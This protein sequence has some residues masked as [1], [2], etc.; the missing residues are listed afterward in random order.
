[1]QGQ[2][3]TSPMPETFEFDRASSSSNS[4]MD[5]QMFWNN[6]LH[7]SVEN[8]DLPNNSLS[9]GDANISCG[10]VPGQESASLNVWDPVGPS[11]SMPPLN[12]G[13]HDEVKLES[14]W[15]P[16]PLVNRVGGPRITD[17]RS[18]SVNTVSFENQNTGLNSS[19]VNNGEELSQFLNFHGLPD[20]SGY[21]SEHVG[22][23]SQVL[24]SGLH[25]GLYNPGLMHR[26]HVPF[27]GSSSGS[28][29]AIDFLSN[30]ERGR[31]ETAQ[32]SSHKRKNIEGTHGECSASGSSSNFSEGINRADEEINARIDTITRV[33]VSDH[34]F[35]SATGSD[36]SFQRSTRMRISHT[37]P[38][39][40]FAPNLWPQETIAHY[41]LWPTHQLS[42]PAVPSNQSSDSRLV[43]SNMGGLRRQ[44]YVRVVP[45]LSS[46]LY[47]LPQSETFTT[48]VG[49]SSGSP[50]LAV[51]GPAGELNSPSVS[52]N[53]SEQ[54]FVPPSNTRHLVQDQTNWG[55][56]SGNT[57]LS[58]SALPTLQVGT[59]LGIHQSP[60]ANW[61]SHQHRRRLSDAVRRSFSSYSESRG[62]SMSVPPRHSHSS[63]SQEVGRH[64]SGP[65]SS[66]HHQPFIRSNMLSR[67]NDGA[68]GIPLSMR[69]LAAAREGRSR[70]SELRNVFD[71]IRRGDN[72]MLEDVL[73]FEQSVF[74]GGA[75]FHDRF[76]DMRLDVDNM[77]YEE[78]LALGERIG[79]VNTGLSEEKILNCLRQRK[80]VSI[81]SEPSEEAEPC[82]I[83]REEYIEGEEL[84]RLDCGHD[85]HTACIKQWL[86]IKNLCPI[87]KTTALNT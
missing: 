31:Q 41:N 67:Q 64:P 40:T 55:L 17:G 46:N 73:L 34:P 56:N 20:N 12:Q 77:S 21:S 74:A 58:G 72:L 5:Q 6:F 16:S 8:Q 33:S 86:V 25:P 69:T 52:N 23:S 11:S 60:A 39:N 66:G 68:L 37:D 87:C 57:V 22:L 83:C 45:G 59:N 3:N 28:S 78:L 18:E 47:P 27:I 24:E 13:N 85:F 65:V 43:S 36:E 32:C 61:L 84:G 19:H 14:S 49:S 48:E 2:R 71:R 7:N 35:G 29:R 42:S 62:R 44:R 53:I 26:E 51:D 75:N 76:R 79:N 70:I 50:A 54:V 81:A 63:A 80:Y 38:A 4:I 9:P 30:N 10:N 1:M 15:M 82:C